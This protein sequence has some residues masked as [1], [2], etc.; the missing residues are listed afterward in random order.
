MWRNHHLSC[1]KSWEWCWSK[2]RSQRENQ[3]MIILCKDKLLAHFPV[4][5]HS[6]KE[7]TIC[8]IPG[9]YHEHAWFSVTMLVYWT[10]F[11]YFRNRCM[12]HGLMQKHLGL[13]QVNWI[14]L[15][16]WIHFPSVVVGSSHIQKKQIK[17]T[18]TTIHNY[19]QKQAVSLATSMIMQESRKDVF[20]AHQVM[21]QNSPFSNDLTSSTFVTL[22]IK[23]PLFRKRRQRHSCSSRGEVLLM[24]H[25]RNDKKTHCKQKASSCN[26]ERITE[27]SIILRTATKTAVFDSINN[28]YMFIY[29]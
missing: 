25:C 27:I 6:H 20:F 28:M 1:R 7:F 29:Q 16:P 10:V 19:Q 4:N 9:K 18:H 8:H 12:A 3:D 24:C 14:K 5:W 17:H 11:Q 26:K 2:S 23:P 22:W 13:C 21:V 15:F